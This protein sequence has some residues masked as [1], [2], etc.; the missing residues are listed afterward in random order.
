VNLLGFFVR[1]AHNIL[2]PSPRPLTNLRKA[3]E[4]QA[5]TFI[6]GVNTLFNGL[7]NEP[8]FCANPPKSL[9]VSLAA[10]CRSR[11]PCAGGRSLEPRWP[12]ATALPKPH[13]S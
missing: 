2:I 10:G 13:R 8:W 5:I 7:L 1:G 4:T 9:R 11:W 3:F 6:T 12:K